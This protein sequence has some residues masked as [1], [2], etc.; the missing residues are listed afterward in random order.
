MDLPDVKFIINDR[1]NVPIPLGGN[2]FGLVEKTITKSGHGRKPLRGQ[3]VTLHVAGFL[4]TGMKPFWNTR[5]KGQRPY[6]F[7]AGVGNVIKGW[8]MGV[9]A[10]RLGEHASIEC[11]GNFGY[12]MKGFPAWQIPPN[13]TIIF[14]CEVLHI[15]DEIKLPTAAELAKKAMAAK[16]VFLERSAA[17]HRDSAVMNFN[18]APF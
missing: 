6:S 15:G 4:K 16:H 14:R 9:M 2:Q 10:M 7:V 13:A 5:D 11:S 18:S 17:D 1:L 12:G 3:T 8:D